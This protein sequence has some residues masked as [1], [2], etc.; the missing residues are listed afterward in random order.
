MSKFQFTEIAW[1]DYLYWQL[2][3]RQTLKKING[4]L[5]DIERNGILNGLGM[6]EALKGELAGFCSRRIDEKKRLIY[7]KAE[8]DVIEIISLKGHYRD[9]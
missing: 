3:D 7:R 4:L 9:K 8:E 5:K 6:P 1:A 2:E